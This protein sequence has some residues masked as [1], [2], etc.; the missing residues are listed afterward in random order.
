MDDP[1]AA[2][3]RQRRWLIAAALGLGAI[4]FGIIV[5][6]HLLPVLG[7][8]EDAALRIGEACVN[9]TPAAGLNIAGKVSGV[10]L[11]VPLIGEALASGGIANSIATGVVGV[12]GALLGHYLARRED[13]TTQIRWSRVVKTAAIL[14][15]AFIAIP[16]ILPALGMGISFLGLLL[17]GMEAAAQYSFVTSVVGT[18]GT[19]AVGPGSAVEGLNVGALILPHLLTCGLSFGSAALSVW[20]VLGGKKQQETQRNAH[21]DSHHNTAPAQAQRTS[22]NGLSKALTPRY[23]PEVGRWGVGPL[24]QP[25][26]GEGFADRVRN[27]RP[28]SKQWGLALGGGG[29]F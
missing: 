3:R 25:V 16:A 2:H 18:L 1:H 22:G 26:E 4:T 11:H 10:L 23:S 15:S 12:W 27:P 28:L 6:P 7:I 24:F 29:D 19:V 20:S 14:T 5:A 9:I 17:P 13:G 21:H 8:G